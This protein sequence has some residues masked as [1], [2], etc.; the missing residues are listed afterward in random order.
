M[1]GGFLGAPSAAPAYPAEP[2]ADEAVAVAVAVA[3]FVENRLY[4]DP[5]FK[6][7]YPAD[8]SVAMEAAPRAAQQRPLVSSGHRTQRHLTGSPI[9]TRGLSG[10][11]TLFPDSVH[12][13]RRTQG[14]RGQDT[15]EIP[16]RFGAARP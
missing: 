4:L 7:A 16:G 5:I 8:M 6:G 14:K 15:H 2:D 11:V 9:P 1:N 12:G 10:T 3:D 13:H